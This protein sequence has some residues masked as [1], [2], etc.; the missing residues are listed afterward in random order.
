MDAFFAAGIRFEAHDCG[1]AAESPPGQV[2]GAVE[3]S[4]ALGRPD[5]RKRDLVNLTTRAVLDLSSPTKPS[6][7]IRW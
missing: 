1:L 5:N 3:V 2:E 4:I 7:V 6:T